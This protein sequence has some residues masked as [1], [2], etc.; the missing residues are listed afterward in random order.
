[1]YL[2]RA[3]HEIAV[4]AT[5]GSHAVLTVVIGSDSMA[6]MAAMMFGNGMFDCQLSI[7]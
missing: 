5:I 4:S 1:M 2:L 3:L 7:E 6:R